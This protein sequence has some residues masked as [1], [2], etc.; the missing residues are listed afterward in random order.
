MFAYR[1]LALEVDVL[2]R[3]E[4]QSDKPF[5][6]ALNELLA[7]REEFSTSFGGPNYA[8]FAR[9]LEETSYGKL[10]KILR[11]ERQFT[12]GFI[13]EVASVLRVAT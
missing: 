2:D 8:A 12:I 11:G 13:Q 10:R 1:T 6:K 9:A 5:K 4:T 7:Q 3:H